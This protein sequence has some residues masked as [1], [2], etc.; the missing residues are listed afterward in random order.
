MVICAEK[1]ED[2]NP[3]TTSTNQAVKGSRSGGRGANCGPATPTL[4]IGL[5]LIGSII[6]RVVGL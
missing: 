5:F 3:M 1:D 4:R 2:V 6:I